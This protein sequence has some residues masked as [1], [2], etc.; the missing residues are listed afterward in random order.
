[1]GSRK[2]LVL[3]STA[4]GG[5]R[6]PVIGLAAALLGRGHDVTILCDTATAGLVATTGISTVTHEVEQV[7]FISRWIEQLSD[8]ESPPNPL[9]EWG[10]LALPAAQGPV[11]E[12]SP[13][14]V[15]SSLFCMGFADLLAKEF[16]IPWCFVN[17]SFYFGEHSLTTWDDDWYG[18]VVPRLAR[19]C[20]APLVERAD[21][22]LHATDPIF[23]FEPQQLP[24]SHH[25][26][27][28][29]PWEPPH[30]IPAFLA[31]PGDPWALV[32]ASTAFPADETML[33]SAVSALAGRAARIVLTLPPT[34]RGGLGKHDLDRMIAPDAV[35]TEY[36]P[37]TPI[38]KESIISINQAGHGIVSKC[39]S[40]GVPM[41]LLPWD[42]DQPGVA[43]R[44]E[45]LGVSTV[46]PR[47]NVS[48]ETVSAAVANVLDEPHYRA[49]AEHVA[50][51]LAE[52]SPMETASAL[53]ER[54]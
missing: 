45:A 13:D 10:K 44:A 16:K 33:R 39:L 32:T 25:Y 50:K 47:A 30:H 14:V 1:M 40:Y 20:F 31:E 21:M 54:L 19:E 6:Q 11:S 48:P 7:G 36:A 52:R 26:V 8:E 9:L 4:G 22:V 43:A 15:V 37:H 29:L 17:P 35:V 24:A 3:L 12:L 34:A 51:V 5:D 49:T 27:G 28:F 53:I 23:D 2:I 18:T 41:V 46:V 42:A 38:L